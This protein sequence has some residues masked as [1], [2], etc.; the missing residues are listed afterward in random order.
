MLELPATP[1]TRSVDAADC[2]VN[3]VEWGDGAGPP[4]LLLHGGMAH[5]RWWDLVAARL[6][7]RLHVFA[8]DLP[9]HGESPWLEPARYAHVEL[10]VIH[11]LLATLAPGP[12]VIGGHS[13]GGLLAVVAASEAGPRVRGLVTVD[14]PADPVA[15]RLVRSGKGFRRMPQPRWTS[16]EEAVRAFRLFPGDGDPAADAVRYVAD[17]SVRA[18]GDGTWTSKF[19]WRYFRG[20]DAEAPNP[21]VG[22]AERLARIGCPTLVVRG[23]RSSIQSAD[24]HTALVA[25]IRGARGVVIAGAGHNPHV[26]RPA[27]TAAAIGAFVP[28]A[29]PASAG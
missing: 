7:S 15:P 5:A 1:R 10:P 23:A 13:N 4:L 2:R 11:A 12:W 24:D 8:V 18:D 27:E 3:V 17:H 29:A 9:G 14:I 19:D 22:F 25:R 26:E 6:A 16:R 20:R 21:Y 28:G